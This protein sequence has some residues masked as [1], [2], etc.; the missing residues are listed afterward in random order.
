LALL[1]L[2]VNDSFLIVEQNIL[3]VLFFGG[4]KMSEET[5][6]A[7]KIDYK[8]RARRAWET[9]RANAGNGSAKK[10]TV[11]KRRG[12]PATKFM[13]KPVFTFS[14]FEVTTA[15]YTFDQVRELGAAAVTTDG[16]SYR[17]LRQNGTIV[18]ANHFER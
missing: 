14:G 10:A 2:G 6:K 8:A 15:V 17:L 9:R 5:T 1:S 16:S 18:L 7:N 12:R 3:T 13:K 11:A 4:L